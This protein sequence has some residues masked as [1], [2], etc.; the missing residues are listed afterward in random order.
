MHILEKIVEK[1]K[2]EVAHNK[3]L[4]PVALLEN[5]PFFDGP[6]VS[7]SKYL[8]REDKSGI[9]AEFKRR[10]PS[11]P[12]INLY[13]DVEEVTVGYMQAGASALSILTDNPFFGGSSNDLII[14]RKNNFCPILRKDFIIDEYQ[15][16]EARSIGAD[17]V[18]LICEILSKNQVKHLAQFALSL[19]LEV[20]LELHSEDQLNK[21]CD[22]V[23]V[24]GVNNRNLKI[25]KTNIDFSKNL[26]P[27]LPKEKVKISESGIHDPGDL[28]DL[29]QIGY[30]G[31]LI[32]EKFMNEAIPGDACKYFIQKIHSLKQEV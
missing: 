2:E 1:K 5:S 9:I 6:T 15:I 11:K 18:L 24:I 16:L 17:A 14:A 7:L 21:I 20:L 26:F 32:G 13:A 12:K 25:F 19:G 22:E 10:S 4:Y 30:Q 3:R 8:L 31:F 23:Q 27:K 29:Q 28:L